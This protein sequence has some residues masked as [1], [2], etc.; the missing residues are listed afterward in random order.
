MK[1]AHCERRV[2]FWNVKGSNLISSSQNLLHLMMINLS[3]FIL[4]G[5]KLL[6]SKRIE[7]ISF[8]DRETFF[9]ALFSKDEK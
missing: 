4:L 3:S 2:P 9:E 8:S 7:R 6:F 1:E 5:V